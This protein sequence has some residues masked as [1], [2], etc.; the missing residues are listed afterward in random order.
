[1]SPGE[2]LVTVGHAE[3]DG[4]RRPVQAML[5]RHQAQS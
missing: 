3:L 1:L 2:L 4:P 5:R